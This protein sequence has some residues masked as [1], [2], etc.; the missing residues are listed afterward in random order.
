MSSRFPH[1]KVPNW[2]PANPTRTEITKSS[3][4]ITFGISKGEKK[5]INEWKFA[6]SVSEM[7]LWHCGSCGNYG[8]YGNYGISREC[9]IARDMIGIG[10]GLF[11]S[12]KLVRVMA[13]K[14]TGPS[15]MNFM[16]G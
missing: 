6:G 3:H 13:S 4:R 10:L 14:M 16:R 15:V 12:P 5:R 2:R 11:P 8:N 7:A 1:V 9:A